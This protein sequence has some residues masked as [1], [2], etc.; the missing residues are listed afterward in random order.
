MILYVI[1]DFKS[2][3]FPVFSGMGKIRIDTAEWRVYESKNGFK[4][5]PATGWIRSEDEVD[6][7]TE[8]FRHRES[9][10]LCRFYCLPFS[11]GYP[12]FRKHRIPET[13][14]VISND[15][16]ADIYLQ[17]GILSKSEIRID[18]ENARILDTGANP[19]VSCN[20]QVA[21][22]HR[23]YHGCVYRFLNVQIVFADGFFM[24]NAPKNL[25][26]DLSEWTSE[27]I[28]TVL[29]L[30]PARR[31]ESEYRFCEKQSALDV[32]LPEL[33]PV[34]R[35]VRTP[36]LL[37]LGPAL[38]MSAASLAGGILNYQTGILNGRPG[39]E[40]LP[41]LLLPAVMMASVLFWYP[42]QRLY[43]IRKTK[44]EA[45]K[46]STAY[47]N[48]LSAIRKA[49]DEYMALYCKGER[50]A[51]LS[52]EAL[53]YK[54]NKSGTC[55][56]KRTFHHDWLLDRIGVGEQPL[57]I[58]FSRQSQ[59]PADHVQEP[60]VNE[61][62]NA[63]RT[64]ANLPV[65][66]NLA[67]HKKI[68]Y[69][70]D[71]PTSGFQQFVLRICLNHHPDELKI[72]IL[73][74]THDY[75]Q[76][77]WLRLIPHLQS[78]RTEESRFLTDQKEEAENWHHILEQIGPAHFL[79]I[80]L[81]NEKTVRIGYDK[82]T[83][84]VFTDIPSIPHDV[85]LCIRETE[86]TVQTGSTFCT[87]QKDP[88]VPYDPYSFFRLLADSNTALN[89]P[90]PH[91][92]LSLLDHRELLK[93]DILRNWNHNC[94]GSGLNI[95]VG[96][97]EN[98]DVITIDLSE[99]GIGPHGLIA[100]MTGSGKSEFL[101]TLI[102]S[103]AVFFSPREV[104]V[105]IVDF[106]GGGAAHVFCNP[107]FQLP[108]LVGTISNLETEE[109]MRAF[110]SFQN[111]CRRRELLFQ[112][113]SDYTGKS[114]MNLAQYQRVWEKRYGIPYIGELVMIIDEFAELKAQYPQYMSDMISIARIGRS[115]G[116]HLILV[117]QKPAGIIDEQ[118]WSN[119]RFKIC[120]KVQSKQDS[121]EVLHQTEASTITEPGEFY[122][123]CDGRLNHGYSAYTHAAADLYLPAV[124]LI[125]KGKQE[126]KYRQRKEMMQID[127][128]LDLIGRIEL[129]ERLRPL[130]LPPLS[131][132]VRTS[133]ALAYEIGI[134][135]D[136][137]EGTQ[138]P[139]IYDTE[140]DTVMLVYGNDRNEREAFLMSLICALGGFNNAD[141]VL[142]DLYGNLF[143]K[144]EELC[145]NCCLGT[146]EQQV[147]DLFERLMERK[148]FSGTKM[149]VLIND[150]SLLVST[151]DT[152][153]RS[154]AFLIEHADHYGL[155]F[156][157]FVTAVHSVPYHLKAQAGTVVALKNDNQQELSN[158]FEKNI[159]MRISDNG[160][161]LVKKKKILPAVYHLAQ[162]PKG[163]R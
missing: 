36:L 146:E 29:H 131:P 7:E 157:L 105:A 41:G 135:D 55:W 76:F 153:R 120:L 12:E 106:K 9:G 1:Q 86:G 2:Y 4:I 26:T 68:I 63:Y 163:E 73:C 124:K 95:P 25:Y 35:P 31:P 40:L 137:S 59:L 104:Q 94:A 82:M 99:N 78:G 92:W 74:N 62:M 151:S 138:E 51:F 98:G 81:K 162:M 14:I 148:D 61:L 49:C 147:S 84:I 161:C 53:F 6:E 13:E 126:I 50:Q 33:K 159:K 155:N 28:G 38:T 24:M 112:K 132:S 3:V 123:L 37:S 67:A 23:I 136:I 43:D 129:K 42:L 34:F 66:I 115:L 65:K 145:L 80:N 142:L 16:E 118:I 85:E 109:I 111:E 119:C 121:I 107:A 144:A 57:P 110:F 141:F 87:Y 20:G 91:D 160:Y 47:R 88:V 100:G 149:I 60:E 96:F 158:L 10:M 83:E 19:I 56:S 18:F 64:C 117:T 114:I 101:M 108:H 44:K 8:L 93:S 152:I 128:V 140:K 58:N 46:R 71:S 17:T 133:A 125:K 70:T 48:G 127:Y 39:R 150:Y 89:H 134:F 122:W 116:I 45:A 30:K 32:N 79:F 90:S 21:S 113:M 69:I 52:A 27:I 156:I 54:W 130:W 102:L 143:L 22:S 77:A 11:D 5:R 139:W 15:I 72:G 97:D 75:N 154:L 103:L